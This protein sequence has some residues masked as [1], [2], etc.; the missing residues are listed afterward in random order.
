MVIF[1]CANTAVAA[2]TETRTRAAN[3][4]VISRGR[5]WVVVYNCEWNL[6]A[7]GFDQTRRQEPEDMQC[8]LLT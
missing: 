4:F 1:V 2:T 5:V 8:A 3:P 7:G 6:S